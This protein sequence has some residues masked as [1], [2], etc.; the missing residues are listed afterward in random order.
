[1]RP[2]PGKAKPALAPE[3]KRS[4]RAK[5]GLMRTFAKRLSKRVLMECWSGRFPADR[6]LRVRPLQ[7]LVVERAKRERVVG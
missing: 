5:H 1:M 2:W 4:P 7:E 6:H 3:L